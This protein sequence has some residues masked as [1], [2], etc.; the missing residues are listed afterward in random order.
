MNTRLWKKKWKKE[1]DRSNKEMVKVPYGSM[2]H[3][4]SANLLFLAAKQEPYKKAYF[5]TKTFGRTFCKMFRRMDQ[6]A[7]KKR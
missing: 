4:P 7:E 1:M 6:Q 3:I 5:V 2:L